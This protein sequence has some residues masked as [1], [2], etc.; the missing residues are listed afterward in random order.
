MTYHV[1]CEQFEKRVKCKEIFNSGKD[2]KLLHCMKKQWLSQSLRVK[3]TG[4][5]KEHQS[6]KI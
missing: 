2:R 6:R 4:Y 3:A 5:V 1:V